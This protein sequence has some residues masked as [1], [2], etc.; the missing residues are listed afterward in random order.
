MARKMSLRVHEEGFRLG[1]TAV[2]AQ[3]ISHGKP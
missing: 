1:S 3:V 2:D